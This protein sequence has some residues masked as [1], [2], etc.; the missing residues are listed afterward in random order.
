[1]NPILGCMNGFRA[2]PSAIQEFGKL[3]GKQSDH[4]NACDRY[5]MSNTLLQQDSE[6]W[7]NQLSG[8]HDALIDNSR[9][10]FQ[11][12]GR[13]TLEG[14]ELSILDSAAYYGRTDAETAADFDSKLAHHT[15]NRSLPDPTTYFQ[16]RS[17]VGVFGET[18]DPA[19]HLGKPDDYAAQGGWR[20][21]PDWSDTVS[22]ASAGRGAIM[23]ATDF[24]AWTGA[25][26]RGYDPYEFLL[27]PVTGDWSGF[28]G[29]ADVFRGAAD[30]ARAVSGN[31]Y[32][33]R[34]G[35]APSWEGK[36]ADSCESFFELVAM[37]VGPAADV[38]DRIGDEYERAAQ[39]AFDF[40][41]VV[42][43][44]LSDLIDAA[45]ILAAAASAG[46]ATG[47]VGWLVGGS[48]AA[49]EAA[50]IVACIQKLADAW[51]VANDIITTFKSGE[52][53]FGRLWA[54]DKMLP[55]LPESGAEGSPMIQLPE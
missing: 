43:S 7:L 31:L 14:A 8:A 25:L 29:C 51:T 3:V 6:G 1:M 13:W 19:S 33:G 36:A 16:E 20:W 41:S 47:P 32:H 49:W 12:L 18:A 26:D 5:I 10:W 46:A 21:Q 15:T 17:R 4:A 2:D 39:G 44:L 35:L 24:L 28:R 52:N 34:L 23:A 38:L 53:S 50:Q 55:A 27:K 37:A 48:I 45:I 11:A 42:G 54:S 22:I 9:V 30:A 40:A